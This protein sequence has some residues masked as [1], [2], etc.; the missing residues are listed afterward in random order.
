MRHDRPVDGRPTSIGCTHAG[1]VLRSDV[2][3]PNEVGV[4][5]ETAVPAAQ[6]GLG[7]TIVATNATAT[8][9]GPA[10]V[11]GVN[12]DDRAA[13]FF[14]FVAEEG[15]QLGKAPAVDTAVLFAFAL[16]DP[17]ANIREVLDDDDAAGHD[18]VDDLP[19]DLMVQVALKPKL[20]ALQPPEMPMGR[21]G[22]FG[23]QG[24]T[25][26]E[27]PCFELTPAALPEELV[28]RPD[29]R[30]DGPDRDPRQ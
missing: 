26:S 9:T 10:G 28:V 16:P 12:A 17:C 14:S 25:E 5:L 24:A 30:T 27:A 18:G 29:G 19:T 3:G 15:A 4:Q 2:S 13:L 20:F 22:A 11:S 23:L 21:P 8:G 1:Q 7:A 6:R